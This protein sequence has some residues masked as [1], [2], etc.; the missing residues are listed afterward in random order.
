[1]VRIFAAKVVAKRKAGA[2]IPDS[3]PERCTVENL[4]RL[5]FYPRK[6]W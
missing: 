3:V 4:I 5:R 1:L 2:E 6:L